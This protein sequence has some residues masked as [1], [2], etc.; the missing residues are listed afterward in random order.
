MLHYSNGL[1]TAPKRASDTRS[2]SKSAIPMLSEWNGS[3]NIFLTRCTTFLRTS[4]EKVWMI[5]SHGCPMENPSR[6]TARSDSNNPSCLFTFPVWVPISLFEDNWIFMEST[7]TDIAPTKTQMV[8]KSK[9]NVN[10][11]CNTRKSSSSHT[12]LHSILV[13]SYSLLSRTSY[14]GS[15]SPLWQDCSKEDES[16]EQKVELLKEQEFWE[17]QKQIKE[18]RSR[19][20]GRY[21]W[22]AK[23]ERRSRIT[24]RKARGHASSYF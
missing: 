4:S 9:K 24:S 18:A 3:Q 10:P 11:H 16:S 2:P 22:S 15:T 1:L 13:Y 21:D 14:P 19:I 20:P 17:Q 8:S 12:L 5:S 23:L 6:F 7:N